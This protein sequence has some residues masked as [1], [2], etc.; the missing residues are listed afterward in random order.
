MGPKAYEVLGNL[1]VM[2]YIS[3]FLSP[4]EGDRSI[5]RFSEVSP[6]FYTASLSDAYWID[7]VE[8][9]WKWKSDDKYKKTPADPDFYPQN[10]HGFKDGAA[11]QSKPRILIDRVKELSMS[12]LRRSLNRVDCGPCV[13]KPDYQ[14][15]LQAYILFGSK[16]L[17]DSKGTVRATTR[18]TKIS[19]PNWATQTLAPGKATFFHAQREA[20]RKN[21]LKSELL[22]AHWLFWFKYAQDEEGNLHS[23]EELHRTR[24]FAI[25]KYRVQFFDDDTMISDMH[26]VRMNFTTQIDETHPL[27]P[28]IS[29]QVEQYPVLSITRLPNGLWRMENTHVFMEQSVPLETCPLV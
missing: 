17:E 25:T 5:L 19:Y 24:G 14:R 16:P 6:D 9:L 18:A 22:T 26:N 29:L 13:E 3:S 1:Q 10:P 8:D 15:M 21:I 27:R 7:Y 4:F 28:L 2:G 20:K 11:K 12:V 23:V